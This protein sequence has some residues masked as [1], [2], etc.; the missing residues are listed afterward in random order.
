MDSGSD[1]RYSVLEERL[2]NDDDI[3]SWNNKLNVNLSEENNKTTQKIMNKK[4]LD[5]YEMPITNSTPNNSNNNN[6]SI[7]N[8]NNKNFQ[9]MITTSYEND[10]DIVQIS[11]P[12]DSGSRILGFG[13]KKH[14]KSEKLLFFIIILLCIV[15]FV[16]TFILLNNIKLKEHQQSA[17][18][19]KSNLSKYCMNDQC[20]MLSGSIFKSLKTDI[21]PCDGMFILLFYYYLINCVY[22]C[23]FFLRF[24]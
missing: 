10:S 7:S 9:I 18:L 14:T 15:I 17:S 2:S 3:K 19:V 20:I 6:T 1:V 8:D 4:I 5:E 23:F 12:I 24:L 21:D 22:K 11:Q 13:G 16:Y